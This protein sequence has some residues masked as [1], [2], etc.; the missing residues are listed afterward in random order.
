MRACMYV[1]G[2]SLARSALP[3]QTLIGCAIDIADGMAY[4]Q[5]C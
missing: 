4:L 3:V 5:V 2:C 1:H